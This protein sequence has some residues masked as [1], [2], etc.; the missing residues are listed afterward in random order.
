MSEDDVPNDHPIANGERRATAAK[1]A[2]IGIAVSGLEQAAH[3][4][5]VLLGLDL[6]RVED[7]PGEGVRAG[8]LPLSGAGAIELLEASR[9][10]STVAKFISRRGAGVH[11]L[12]FRVSDCRETIRRAEAAGI[13]PLPPAPRVGA[14]GKLVAFFHPQDTG[15]VLI[16]ICEP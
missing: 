4:F 16:E 7:I 3:T 8:F 10:D 14:G 11:H 13:R 9:P 6:E 12:S 1:L 5:R 2:H 15:G